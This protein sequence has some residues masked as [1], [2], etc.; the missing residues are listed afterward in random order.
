MEKI[1]ILLTC[2][3]RKDKTI[4]CL[5]S[6]YRAID[7]S[8]HKIKFDIYL[9]DD[10][11]T[12]G[13]NEEISKKFPE[14]NITNG[15]GELFWSGGMRLAWE[16]A[17]K[18]DIDYDAFLLLNDDVVLNELFLDNLL[19]THEFCLKQYNQSGIYACSTKD[20]LNSKISYGGTLITHRG[21]KIK[22]KLVKPTDVPTPCTMANANILMVTKDVVKAIGILD[23]KY[24]HQFGDYD[25]TLMASEHKIPVLVCP[26]FGGICGDDHGNS[27]LP[28]NSSLKDRINYLFSPLGLGYNEQSYYLKKHFKYQY[29][30]YFTMLWLKTLFPFIWDKFKKTKVEISK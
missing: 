27:W 4:N 26:G 29:P 13:T 2:H 18:Q 25:Y 16:T 24:I 14:I 12:D 23:K 5:K 10:G 3:N 30:Y 19:L 20:E 7:L 21:F 15:S 28:S 1:A 11:S 17:L 22:S 9:V 6:V 8:K